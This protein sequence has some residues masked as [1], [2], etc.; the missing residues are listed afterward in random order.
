M[1]SK[2]EQPRGEDDQA[3][4]RELRRGPSAAPWCAS[5]TGARLSVRFEA[6]AA[7]QRGWTI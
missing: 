7:A 4:S 5:R 1:S 2:L 6:Q 3:E